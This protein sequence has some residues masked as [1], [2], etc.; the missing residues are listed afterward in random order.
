MIR[1]E[2]IGRKLDGIYVDGRSWKE[3]YAIDSRLEYSDDLGPLTG[4]WHINGG[5]FCMT[6]EPQAATF[7]YLVRRAGA[8]CYEF[9][10]VPKDWTRL[11]L[12]PDRKGGWTAKGGRSGEADGCFDP[13]V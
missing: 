5:V 10:D 9:Y 11:E 3:D 2:I 8:N 7:C 4:H 1:A 13:T 12:P 6:Y